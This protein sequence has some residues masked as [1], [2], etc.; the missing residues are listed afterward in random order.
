MKMNDFINFTPTKDTAR[1]ELDKIMRL[2]DDLEAFY[3]QDIA[4]RYRNMMQRSYKQYFDHG[5]D[6][7]NLLVCDF[8]DY[9]EET[10][11]S[12]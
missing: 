5:K 8:E 11:K 4:Y 3:L 6:N 12:H 1:S 2:A 10:V 9:E 7:D